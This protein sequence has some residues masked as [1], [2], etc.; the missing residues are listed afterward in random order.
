MMAVYL[1]D[2]LIDRSL[3]LLNKIVMQVRNLNTKAMIFKILFICF[4]KKNIR[5]NKIHIAK[6]PKKCLF[7]KKS[8]FLFSYSSIAKRAVLLGGRTQLDV[9][10][11]NANWQHIAICKLAV[12]IKNILS[13]QYYVIVRA[14]TLV[15][16]DPQSIFV[17]CSE[18]V[19][20]ELEFSKT[21]CRA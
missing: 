8:W 14:L 17:F 1:L 3:K 4:A 16:P 11:Q 21:W 2:I 19:Q 5:F 12:C 7:S 18:F 6:S 20:S 15:G 9:K 10:L 13:K